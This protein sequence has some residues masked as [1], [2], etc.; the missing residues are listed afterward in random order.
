M[1]GAAQEPVGMTDITR[2]IEVDRD[3]RYRVSVSAQ[4]QSFNYEICLYPPDGAGGFKDGQVIGYG[5]SSHSQWVGIGADI[6]GALVRVCVT[7]G[8]AMADGGSDIMVRLELERGPGVVENLH[9]WKI[10]KG[11]PAGEFRCLTIQFK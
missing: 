2:A 3:E 8:G 9:A 7:P 5:D 10:L 4:M 6:E 1:C 11:L